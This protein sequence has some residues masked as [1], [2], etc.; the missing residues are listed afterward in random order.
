MLG[1]L[2]DES[3]RASPSSRSKLSGVGVVKRLGSIVP[4]VVHWSLMGSAVPTLSAHLRVDGLEG[5][6]GAHR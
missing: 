1:G 3:P 2:G 5:F 4:T 6:K